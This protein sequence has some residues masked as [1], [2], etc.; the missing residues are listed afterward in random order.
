ME[1]I[2]KYRIPVRIALAQDEAVLGTVF[3]RQEQRILDMLRE[4]KP[5]FPVRTRTGLFFVSK[6]SVIKV[7]VLDE[8]Y[9]AEHREDFPED[10]GDS[11]DFRSHAQIARRRARHV[12]M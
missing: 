10:S 4:P 8:D 3:V 6:Q 11:Y 7:E 5:F 2:P 12:S 1:R 9:V